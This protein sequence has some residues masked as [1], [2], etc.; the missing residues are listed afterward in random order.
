MGMNCPA[1]HHPARVSI[2]LALPWH[3]IASK[4]ADLNFNIVTGKLKKRMKSCNAARPWGP[5]NVFSGVGYHTHN[6]EGYI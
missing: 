2:N 1:Y 4:I 6:L 3:S 5:K